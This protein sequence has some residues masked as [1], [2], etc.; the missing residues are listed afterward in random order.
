MGKKIRPA[1]GAGVR[2]TKLQALRLKLHRLE[3]SRP[4]RDVRRA[5]AFIKERRIVMGSGRSSLPLLTEAIAGRPL[6]GSWMAHP[7][8][9]RIYRIWGKLATY[10]LMTVPLILGKE[11]LLDVSLQPA[12]ERIASDPERRAK[13]RGTLPPLARRLLEQVEA[14]GQ[15]RMDRWGVSTK[16]ARVARVLLERELLVASAGL[17]TEYGYHT[18]LVAPWSSSRLS[19]RFSNKATKLTLGEAQDQLL[20]AAIR[21][22]V[23]V[24]LQEVQHWFTFGARRLEACLDQGKLTRFT[25]EARTWLTCY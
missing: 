2:L 4:L 9:S 25:A 17:H 22:A 15:I 6:A 7:E 24:P 19:R 21:S 3:P 16:Q 5:A 8:A 1:I 13:V 14:K 20:L 18:S 23:V 12:V 10:E 11:T